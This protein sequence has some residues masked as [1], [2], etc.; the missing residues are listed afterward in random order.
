MPPTAD[1]Q[2]PAD[3]LYPDTTFTDAWSADVGEERVVA[4]YHGRAHT[5]G[6]AVITCERANV[7]HPGDLLF[8]RRHPVVDRAA[9]ATI[10]NRIAVLEPGVREHAREEIRA[11]RD[12]LQG[13]EAFGPLRAARS[14][15]G[16]HLRLRGDRLAGRVVAGAEG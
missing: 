16:P 4:R 7:V 14:A 3:A 15:G 13:F 6:D 11:R 5:S 12:P 10:R 1:S 2:F 9:G 8:N